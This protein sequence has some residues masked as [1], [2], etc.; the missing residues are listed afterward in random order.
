MKKVIIAI[1]LAVVLVSVLIAPV[2]A[3]EGGMPNANAGFGQAIK[4]LADS[5]TGAV[6]DMASHGHEGKKGTPPAW[7]QGGIRANHP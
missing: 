4:A 3:D 6:G 2:L 7:S 5:E 1:A